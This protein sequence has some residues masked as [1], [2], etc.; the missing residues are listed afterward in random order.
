MIEPYDAFSTFKYRENRQGES[1][2]VLP[3]GLRTVAQ[4]KTVGFIKLSEII[5]LLESPE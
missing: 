1:N 4:R 2:N 5:V 3:M